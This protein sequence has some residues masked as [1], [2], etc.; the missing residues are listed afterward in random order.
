MIFNTFALV[1]AVTVTSH[2]NYT[3]TTHILSDNTILGLKIARDN[4]VLIIVVNNLWN[5]VSMASR[6]CFKPSIMVQGGKISFF[7]SIVSTS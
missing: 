2:K 7:S 4:I 6:F 5:R 3:P 1:V